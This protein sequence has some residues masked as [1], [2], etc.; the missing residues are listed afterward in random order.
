M[1]KIHW[2]LGIAIL[3]MAFAVVKPDIFR[4][5]I[6]V[7]GTS[8][9]RDTTKIRIIQYSDGSLITSANL[10]RDYLTILQKS[11]ISGKTVIFQVLDSNAYNRFLVTSNGLIVS[12][13]QHNST[14]NVDGLALIGAGGS[15]NGKNSMSLG[16]HTYNKA[17]TSFMLGAF[18]D[19]TTQ[20]NKI[21]IGSGINATQL[22]SNVTANSVAIGANETTPSFLATSGKITIQGVLNSKPRSSAPSSPVEGDIYVNNTDHHAYCYLSGTWKQIDN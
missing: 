2:I 22:L 20:A 17:D 14:L 7:F 10:I 16:Y 12:G 3:S 15:L 11:G 5:G 21:T 9:L 8:E 1:K 13:R 4:N 19:S 18:I 6:R